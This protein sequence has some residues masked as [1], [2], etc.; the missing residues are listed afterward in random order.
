MNSTTKTGVNLEVTTDAVFLPLVTAFVEKAA[1]ALGMD[2]ATAKALMT[3][4][5]EVFT[6]L[7]H[8]GAAE[9]DVRIRCSGKGYYAQADFD[10]QAESFNMHA[11]NMTASYGLPEDLSG[12]EN[13]Q[14]Q[15]ETHLLSASRMVDR[16]KLAQSDDGFRLTL[17]KE[18]TYPAASKGGLPKVTPLQSYS[19][20]K[21]D[22]EELKIFVRMVVDQYDPHLV[23]SSFHFPGKVA[24]M[25]ACG[26]Y[27]AALAVDEEGRIGGGIIW[28]WENHQMVECYG[29]YVVSEPSASSMP[30]DLLDFCIGAIAR[31]RALGLICR[32]PTPELPLEYFE[33]LGDLTFLQSDGSLLELTAWYRHFDE[34]LGTTVWAHPLLDDFLAR[35]YERL[36]FAR[37][38]VHTADGGEVSSPFSAL[39]AEFHQAQGRV[40]LRPLWWG[41]DALETLAAHVALLQKEW[42]HCMTFE[43]D[44]GHPWET[45]FAPALF[46]NGFEPRYVLPY[47]GK[48]DLIVFEHRVHGTRP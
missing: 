26:D 37:E 7:S 27:R 22:S 1:L 14:D 32:Y 20:V 18:R 44:L 21:P 40:V 3:A 10:F 17:I 11:F 28:I 2:D 36:A 46:E 33:T 38:I 5:G 25:A 39:S 29:P 45:R 15:E 48:S 8:I 31:S 19:V 24:D 30:H 4:C 42:I 6:Y 12:E 13:E 35:E 47:G 41:Q 34:D 23:P 16:F 9:N 43:M